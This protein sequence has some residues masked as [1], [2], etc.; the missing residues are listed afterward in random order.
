MVARRWLTRVFRVAFCA[1]PLAVSAPAWSTDVWTSP[2]VIS[3]IFMSP[4]GNYYFRVYG[5]PS[6]AICPN[7]PVWGY[8]ELADPGSQG[9]MAGLLALYAAGT[10]VALHVVADGNGYCH[11]SEFHS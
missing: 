6:Q 5:M 2:F 11:I 4:P 3:S 8:V 1:L 7:G 9:F 10:P